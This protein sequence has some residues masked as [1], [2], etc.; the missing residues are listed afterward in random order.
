MRSMV[1]GKVG[2][3]PSCSGAAFTGPVPR[4]SPGRKVAQEKKS[5]GGEP[6]LAPEGR[7]PAW[8]QRL[9]TI[10]QD[11]AS[12][13]L[14][15]GV[16]LLGQSGRPKELK[17]CSPG[18]KSEGRKTRES[19]AAAREDNDPNRDE[20]PRAQLPT[21]KPEVISPSVRRGECS[22][23]DL[24]IRAPQVPGTSQPSALSVRRVVLRPRD[25]RQPVHPPRPERQQ[26]P[27]GAQGCLRVMLC[28]APR[29]P[30]PH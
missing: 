14:V 4:G 15:S 6:K 23:G 16:G 24:A 2:V 17:H 20:V 18:K 26:P 12:F 10:P 28:V 5:L 25:H 30:G 27:P 13:P 29:N 21:H 11:P 7:F 3:G 22:S 9:S 8:R 19:Q 1:W